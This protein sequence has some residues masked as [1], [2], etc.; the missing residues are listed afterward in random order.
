[1]NLSWYKFTYSNLI[2]TKLI[3]TNKNA[4]RLQHSSKS[5]SGTFRDFVGCVLRTAKVKVAYQAVLDSQHLVRSAH[6]TT[7]FGSLHALSKMK[8]RLKKF[9]IFF[10]KPPHN[11]QPHKDQDD[12]YSI[13]AVF[14][15]CL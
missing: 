10:F 8:E 12:Y 1:M 6:P 3:Y 11:D 15:C 2:Y 14:R 5:F 13:L 7:L 9:K 4:S